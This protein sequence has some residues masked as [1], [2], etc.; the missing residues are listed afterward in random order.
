MPGDRDAPRVWIPDA[1][2]LSG[3][4]VEDR[5]NDYHPV[6][7]YGYEALVEEH[8]KVGGEEEAVVDVEAF[9]VGGAV[10]PRFDVAGAEE[11]GDGQA[12]DRTTAFPVFHQAL[13]ENVL[14][15]TLHH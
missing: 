11:F 4:H 7:P 14:A 12:G 10:G 2:Q 5:G 3:R 6:I 15:D 9:G 8:V 13:T 1:E